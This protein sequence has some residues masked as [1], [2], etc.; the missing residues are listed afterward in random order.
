MFLLRSQVS[1][2]HLQRTFKCEICNAFFGN[3]QNV[4]EH[5]NN[6]HGERKYACPICKVSK[7]KRKNDMWRHMK[8]VHI[9]VM[10]RSNDEEIDNNEKEKV[11][12]KR[13]VTPR[14]AATSQIISNNLNGKQ[15]F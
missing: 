10:N 5:I 14:R 6:V 4:K 3:H 15:H 11:P 12:K 1:Q 8:N 13:K 7:F 2:E 9:Y